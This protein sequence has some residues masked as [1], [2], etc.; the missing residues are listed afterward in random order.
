[1]WAFPTTHLFSKQRVYD[2]VV[3]LKALKDE[4]R[5]RG[6]VLGLAGQRC[7]QDVR[8]GAALVG[9]LRLSVY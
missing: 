3:H 6:E 8:A 4:G 7:M 5:G 1:M 2:L 9:L